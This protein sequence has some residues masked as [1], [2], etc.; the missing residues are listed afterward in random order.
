M[1]EFVSAILVLDVDEATN[2]ALKYMLNGHD[3]AASIAEGR[4]V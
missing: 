4:H 1:P 3:G 2:L